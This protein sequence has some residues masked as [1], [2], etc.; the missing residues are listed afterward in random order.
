MEKY[1][2]YSKWAASSYHQKLSESFI[3]KHFDKLDKYYIFKYQNLSEQFIK[4]YK[5]KK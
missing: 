3:E 4:R 1:A 2:Q 5:E